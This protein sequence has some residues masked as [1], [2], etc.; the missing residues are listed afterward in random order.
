MPERMSDGDETV[1][2]GASADGVDPPSAGSIDLSGRQPD[3][4]DD[5][6]EIAR[7]PGQLVNIDRLFTRETFE[8]LV[9]I[10]AGLLVLIWPD[11][12]PAVTAKIIGAVLIT[13]AVIDISRELRRHGLR[14]MA[15]PLAFGRLAW[16]GVGIVLVAWP[17]ATASVILNLVVLV[18]AIDGIRS[19]AGMLSGWRLAEDWT[20]PLA[21]GLFK[22]TL[23]AALWVAGDTMFDLAVAIAAGV[24]ILAGA[25]TVV[26]NLRADTEDEITIRDTG[27]IMLVWLDGR[28]QTADDRQV[29][30]Q[31]L[32]YEGDTAGRRLSRFFVLMFFAATIASFGVIQDSTA[33]VIGAMLIAPLMTPLMGTAASVIMGWPRRASRSAATAFF[34]ALLAVGIG[35]IVAFAFPIGLSLEANTQITSRVSP[36]LID[37]AI[38]LAAGAR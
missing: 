14:R 20:W 5:Y 13:V 29:L 32:F 19:L 31:K 22:L 30:Y 15:G 33:V 37:M 25:I 21:S 6:F 27:G 23:A 17:D 12:G 16:L 3:E 10:F 28:A 36:T 1:T 24:A 2:G 8:G 18:I 38:A 4:F 7:N 9:L 11:E 35:L 34:G 26:T